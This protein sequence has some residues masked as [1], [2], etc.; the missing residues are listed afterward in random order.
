MIQNMKILKYTEGIYYLLYG[1]FPMQ[2]IVTS[3]LSKENNCWLKNLTN[4][5]YRRE[6][7]EE[8]FLEYEK[9]RNNKLHKSV[10][11]IIVRANERVFK[12]VRGSMCDALVELMQDVIDEKVAEGRIEVLLEQIR[13]KIAKGK[14]VEQIADELEETVENIK[15]LMT[16]VN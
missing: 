16:K 9:H 4:S 5:L 11:D 6:E 2:V 14:T 3:E 12:E 7:A 8:I 15:I 10:M 1:M 13:K